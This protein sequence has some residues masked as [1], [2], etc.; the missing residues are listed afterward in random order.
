MHELIAGLEFQIDPDGDIL[1]TI[2]YQPTLI[3]GTT[4]YLA[5]RLP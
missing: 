4:I 5:P 1:Q 2:R 3:S